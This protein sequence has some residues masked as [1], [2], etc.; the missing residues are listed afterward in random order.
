MLN[1]KIVLAVII[2]FALLAISAVSAEDNSSANINIQDNDYYFDS[3]GEDGN[4]S[5]ENPYKFLSDERIVNNSVMHFSNGEYYLNDITAHSNISFIGQDSNKTIINGNG[6]L[7]NVSTNLILRNITIVNLTTYNQGTLEAYNVVFKECNA[8]LGDGGA[9]YSDNDVYLDN[10]TFLNNHGESG[11]AIYQKGE[12]LEIIDCKFLSN[13]AYSGG[14][15]CTVKDKSKSVVSIKNTNFIN[16][17]IAGSNL[18][19]GG[20]DLRCTNGILNISNCNFINSTSLVWYGS[21]FLY[22][23]ENKSFIKNSSFINV[24]C[25]E[26]EGGAIF[27]SRTH[28]EVSDS[29]F[30]NATSQTGS[31][32]YSYWGGV[33]IIRCEFINC[34]ATEYGGGA[35]RM[36]YDKHNI[37]DSKFINCN[38]YYS[39]GA[40]FS[41]ANL[42][43]SGCEFIN[44]SSNQGGAIHCEESSMSLFQIDIS[45]SSFYG[46]DAQAF[47]GAIS[48]KSDFFNGNDLNISFSK[49]P[50]GSIFLDNSNSKLSNVYVNDNVADYGAGIYQNR[51][52]LILSNSTFLNNNAIFC[53]GA[54]YSM[55]AS[56]DLIS[57][58]LF[59]NNYANIS[60]GAIYYMFNTNLS[61][62]EN[63]RFENASAPNCDDVFEYYYNINVVKSANS[64]ILG[65]YVA[66]DTEIP[67]YFSLVDLGYVTPVK[68][69]GPDGNCWAF[70]TIGTLE[71][72]ILKNLG[73]E[74]DL[75]ENNLNN[76][77]NRFAYY[78]ANIEPNIGGYEYF[79]IGYLTSW[80]GP[81]Y[82]IDDPYTHSSSV[83]QIFENI[84]QVQNIAYLPSESLEDYEVIKK[85]L[86]DHGA[87][88]SSIYTTDEVEQYQDV[89]SESNHIV[90]IVGWDDDKE[91]QN[92]PGKGAWIVRNSWG[93][94]WG[95]D[96]YFYVSYYDISFPNNVLLFIL[97][98]TIKYDKNYQYD[99]ANTNFIHFSNDTIWYKNVFNATD[100]EYLSAVSTYFEK[101]SF[102]NI[103]VYVN[104]EFKLIKSGFSNAG[105]H[106]IDL[107]EFIPLN[108]GDIFE[109]IFEVSSDDGTSLPIF[110][111]ESYLFN[112]IYQKFYLYDAFYENQSF[113]SL[114]GADW[115]D[116]SNNQLNEGFFEF[117]SQCACIKAFTVLNVINTTLSLDVESD[118]FNPVNLTAKVLNQ[119]GFEVDA[120]KVIFNL[121]GE[122]VEANVRGGIAKITHS[123][124]NESN[125][126]S[127]TFIAGGYNSS[128][129]TVSVDINLLE[130]YLSVSNVTT[131]YKK[132]DY[133]V[134]TLMDE[135]GNPVFGEYVNIDL[136]G[137][138][139]RL[140]TDS[141]GQVS[142]ST[143]ALNPANYTA[144]ITFEGNDFY[145]K[146]NA[147]AEISVN[148]ANATLTVAVD[149]NYLIMGLVNNVTGGPL[150]GAN[151]I[152][153]INGEK[154]KV[155]IDAAGQ[156]ILYLG[157]LDL[158]NYTATVSY[159]GGSKYEAL[160][161]TLDVTVTKADTNLSAVYDSS[162]KEMVVSLVDA[163][164][165][166]PLKGANVLV[167]IAG[168]QY[169]VK[170]NSK[171][172]GRLSL[173]ELD[174]GTYDVA[175]KYKGNAKY[176]LTSVE[177]D[178]VV[179]DAVDLSAVYNDN[180]K[181]LV[182]SLVDAATGGPL[183]GAN[184]VV[185]IDGADYNV[186]IASAGQGKLSLAELSAGTYDA[187][188]Y[189]KGNSIYN[190]TNAT[191]NFVI[192]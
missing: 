93:D 98:N 33:D 126:V 31:G 148:K 27:T 60:G 99:L 115:I 124:S 29:K 77:E 34:S 2:I 46:N 138:L 94:K 179:K 75:S 159:K 114:N 44:C 81:V 173:A 84:F 88:Y 83:S 151:V 53:G 111:S 121:S 103:S 140:I 132:D 156:G 65:R 47:G 162:T 37:T 97:N 61:I 91:I 86:M 55:A 127:A 14:A 9:I 133:L 113:F 154:Y 191:V 6:N 30:I 150:K 135:S 79:S 109:V 12:L 5:K 68:D 168:E 147:T 161:T 106:T 181:E 35:I 176:A 143:R 116:L 89:I 189:Y 49:S 63:N 18:F 104:N 187:D 22:N 76:L 43:I 160:S 110:A 4:G 15:I 182:V 64:T 130:T 186:R 141:N 136:N 32:I 42:N 10:C 180:A 117:H 172:E 73:I 183:K 20:S 28:M 177:L 107:G 19:H 74:T 90:A 72:V 131:V 144:F 171:G 118:G 142:L 1:K 41:M 190:P 48:I 45:S 69:Q 165:G 134:V 170:I 11:G 146:S 152:V 59:K 102:W 62:E 52:S 39:G 7:L 129:D 108:K 58:N 66:N 67:S 26:G 123:F 71:S 139:N 125:I 78:G 13:Q 87:L 155:Y 96:G 100:N 163:F 122:I 112:R 24:S 192:M 185:N 40:I 120:G 119:Y 174:Y 101:K 95:Y 38:A 17:F 128:S 184:V 56:N 25:P 158:G 82:E 169:S 51:G 3:N 188:L 92:A 145:K 54:L 70:A 157:D 85:A 8:Y 153:K 166:T 80:L 50:L 57:N 21:I 137:V 23:G 105:Y 16:N 175:L 164:A 167:D 178:V 36:Q 149:N